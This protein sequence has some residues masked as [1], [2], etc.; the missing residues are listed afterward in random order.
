MPLWQEAQTLADAVAEVIVALPR[1]I[2]AEVVGR[3]AM[4][5]AGSVAANIAEGYG[6]YSRAAYRNYLGIARASLFEVASW[7]DL[8]GRRKL[9]TPEK[10]EALV[11]QA[12]KVGR[13]LTVRMKSLESSP[14]IREDGPEYEA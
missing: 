5:A 9:I 1:R 8:L 4:R 3:Q 13:M 14:S 6:R 12:D 11:A 7:L 2:D 10:L